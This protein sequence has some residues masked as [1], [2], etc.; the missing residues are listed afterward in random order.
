MQHCEPS[1][2]RYV[3][4][5][6]HFAAM[7]AAM[8]LRDALVPYIYTAGVAALRTGVSLLRPMYYAWP[9]EELAYAPAHR[10]QYMC[11]AGPTLTSLC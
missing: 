5:F 2:D 9:E 7:R 10:G 8:V 3:W 11:D 6:P 1:C 4:T